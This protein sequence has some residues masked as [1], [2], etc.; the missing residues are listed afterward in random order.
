MST[1]R[2]FRALAA[3]KLALDLPTG[4]VRVC[5]HPD[6]TAVT[7]LLAT[8]DDHGP[9]ADAVNQA[10]AREGRNTLSIDVPHVDSGIT[11]TTSSGRTFTTQSVFTGNVTGVTIVNGRVITGGSTHHVGVS[12]VTA[13]VLLPPTALGVALKT[14]S[15]DLTA[16]GHLGVV[17]VTSTSG[18]VHLDSV[19]VLSATTV[20]GDVFA[21]RTGADAEIRTTSGDVR[22]AVH[23]GHTATVDTVSGDV[24]LTAGTRATGSVSVRTVSGDVDLNG[25]GH[26]DVTA[27]TVSGHKTRR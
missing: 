20:S 24:R 25:T 27:R 5:V 13:T 12:P 16:T 8:D 23:E 18:D 19:D 15:A 1:A 6:A 2:T 9:A 7:V 3:D 11:I 10:R 4:Q 26:L 17:S 22:I 14:V 21:R